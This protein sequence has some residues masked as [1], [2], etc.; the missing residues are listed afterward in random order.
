MTDMASLRARARARLGRRWRPVQ[1]GL[2]AVSAVLLVGACDPWSGC[3]P[4]PSAQRST[5]EQTPVPSGAAF[6]EDF[7]TA[8]GVGRFDWQLHSGANGGPCGTG[9]NGCGLID[10]TDRAEHDMSCGAPTTHRH[11]DPQPVHDF[12]V[13]DPATSPLMYHCAPGNDAAKGHV[14]TI[15]ETTGVLSLS[16][17][18]RQVFTDI[19]KLCFDINTNNNMGAG[20]WINAWIIPTW[21][22]AENGGRFDFADQPDLDPEQ[23]VPGPEDWHMKYFDGSLISSS[24]LNW[25]EWSRRASESATRFTQCVE[26]TGPNQLTYTRDFPADPNGDSVLDPGVATT[27]TQTGPGNLPDGPVRVIF[28]DGSYN[29]DKHGGNGGV[30]WH[31]DNITIS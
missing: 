22:L 1:S 21:S 18:P 8:A 10:A 15:V 27:E 24:G 23:E 13:L 11:I 31:W 12:L 14:M 3:A 29:P 30:T 19:N 20:K 4:Q 25:W 16:F 28:Q 2:L 17:S 9:N 6:F 5:A 26:Q 7:A